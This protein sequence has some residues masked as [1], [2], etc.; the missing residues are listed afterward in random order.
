MLT[1]IQK[2]IDNFWISTLQ[3][4]IVK[5]LEVPRSLVIYVIPVILCWVSFTSQ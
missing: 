4:A 2:P 5:T 1:K 3:L